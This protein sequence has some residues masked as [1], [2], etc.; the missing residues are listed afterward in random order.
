LL[1]P[2]IYTVFS[3]LSPRSRPTASVNVLRELHHPARHVAPMREHGSKLVDLPCRLPLATRAGSSLTEIRVELGFPNQWISDSRCWL[4]LEASV[5]WLD[6]IL[7]IFANA[8]LGRLPRSGAV[9]SPRTMRIATFNINNVNKRLT[10]ARLAESNKAR[11]G[12][13][14]RA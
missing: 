9:P 2:F 4:G 10:T 7:S 12:L 1:A 13:R 14:A 3:L 5:R 11:R 6:H 8:W